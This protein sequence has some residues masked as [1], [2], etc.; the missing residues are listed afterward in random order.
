MDKKLVY[1]LTIVK[2]DWISD[3]DHNRKERSMSYL[4]LLYI[5]H[6]ILYNYI[7]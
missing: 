3:N 7:V 5:S 4:G 6:Y 2:C 1:L